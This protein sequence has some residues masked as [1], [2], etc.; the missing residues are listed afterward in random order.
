MLLTHGVCGVV[1]RVWVIGVWVR[2]LGVGYFIGVV[3]FKDQ[4]GLFHGLSQQYLFGDSGLM[5]IS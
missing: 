2:F 5:M 1:S 4:L 3:W